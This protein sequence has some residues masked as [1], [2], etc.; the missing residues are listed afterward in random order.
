MAMEMVAERRD[1]GR[2]AIARGAR[3]GRDGAEI[4]RTFGRW[5]AA[6][7]PGIGAGTAEEATGMAADC[8]RV[9]L[10]EVESG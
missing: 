8:A 9:G 10:P 6:L 4:G 7:P 1:E 3:G 2:A 5:Y